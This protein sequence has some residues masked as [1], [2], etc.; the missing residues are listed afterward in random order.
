MAYYSWILAFHI[1]SVLSWMAMLFYLP[2]LFV[3]HREHND[4]DEFVE[5]VQIQEYKLYKYIGAPAM[6]ATVISGSWLMWINPSIF[7]QGIWFYVKFTLVILLM[8]YSFSLDYYRRVLSVD[9][10]AKSGKFF[11]FYNEVPTILSIGIV[12]MVVVR[13]F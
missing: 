11:R 7:Q 9:K 13:P 5:V 2:R 4:K 3:Y 12:V 1:V 10:N 8:I 6:W